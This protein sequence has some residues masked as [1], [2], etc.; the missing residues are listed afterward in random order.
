M[1]RIASG[2]HV[3]GIEHLLGQLGNGQRSV[4][5]TTPGGQW[6]KSR[7]EKVKTREGNHV[8]GQFSQICIK[9]SRESKTSSYSRHG[10]GDQ[11][12]EITIGRSCQLKS[13]EANVIKSLI[14]DTESL[15]S[16]L[17]Q[18]MNRQ[19]SIVRFYDGVRDFGGGDDGEGVHDTV[20]VLLADL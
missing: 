15:V 20:R 5:L 8:N 19:S 3:L 18:L 9:L 4:L 11:M 17:N 1:T 6:S 7:H 14:V 10:Q 2:H 16:I 13:T 12:V